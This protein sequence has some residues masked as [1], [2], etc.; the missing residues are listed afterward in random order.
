MPVEVYAL[1]DRCQP[2]AI[3]YVGVTRVGVETR[4]R[5]HLKEARRGGKSHK[6]RWIQAVLAH[7]CDVE[8]RVLETVDELA[9]SEAERRWVEAARAAGCELTNACAGGFGVLRPSPEARAKIVAWLTADGPE[10][11]EWKRKLAEA[12]RS[13]HATN[14]RM[15]DPD[16]RYRMGSSFRGKVGPMAG[17]THSLATLEKISA[18][19]R[20]RQTSE[21]V[22]RRAASLRGRTYELSGTPEERN[23]FYRAVQLRRRQGDAPVIALA[24][25]IP[26]DVVER[27]RALR[28]EGHPWSSI[29]RRLRRDY[30]TLATHW[31]GR[32]LLAFVV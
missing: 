8:A 30:P 25:R 23:E 29:E 1:V 10:Q 4:R 9:W 16:V 17:K 15:K 14:P 27:A 22:E 20:R 7:G 32:Y 31:R 6:S 11:R 19:S 26:S 18:S 2:D 12:A 3:R 24:Q 28:V 5:G 13:Q 21:T